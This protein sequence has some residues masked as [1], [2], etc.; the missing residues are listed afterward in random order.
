MHVPRSTDAFGRVAG[1]EDA[2]CSSQPPGRWAVDGTASTV[3]LT[4]AVPAKRVQRQWRTDGGGR[5]TERFPP[6]GHSHGRRA[7]S[8]TT[9]RIGFT[10]LRLSTGAGDEQPIRDT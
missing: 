3:A 6:T 5:S 10:G 4:T 2:P 9:V 7:Q 1:R 8:R